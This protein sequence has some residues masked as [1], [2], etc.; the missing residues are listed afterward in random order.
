MATA[1]TVAEAVAA[2]ARE[3]V[4]GLDAAGQKS[5]EAQEKW[6]ANQLVRSR[7]EAWKNQE[8]LVGRRE[9]TFE[10]LEKARVDGRVLYFDA[11]S[12]PYTGL[13]RAVHPWEAMLMPP[14]KLKLYVFEPASESRAASER[15]LIQG[16]FPTLQSLIHS[17]AAADFKVVELGRKGAIH[18]EME[19]RR[20]GRQMLMKG[21]LQ[22]KTKAYGFSLEDDDRFFRAYD[23]EESMAADSRRWFYKTADLEWKINKERELVRLY[24]RSVNGRKKLKLDWSNPADITKADEKGFMPVVDAARSFWAK[25]D[26]KLEKNSTQHFQ[27]DGMYGFSVDGDGYLKEIYKDEPALNDGIARA[28]SR[29][30]FASDDLVL[31]LAPAQGDLDPLADAQGGFVGI[32]AAPAIGKSSKPLSIDFGSSDRAPVLVKGKVLAIEPE[33]GAGAGMTLKIYRSRRKVNKA[34]SASWAVQD[35]NQEML[36]KGEEKLNV[37]IWRWV[38][39]KNQAP[40]LLHRDYLE[41]RINRAESG[42]RSASRW[43]YMPYNWHN[44]ASEVP[45][46]VFKN[47]VQIFTGRDLNNDGFHGQVRARQQEGGLVR[48]GLFRKGLRA[49]DILE[50]IPDQARVLMDPTEFPSIVEIKGNLAPGEDVYGKMKGRQKGGKLILGKKFFNRMERYGRENEKVDLTMPEIFFN[51]GAREIFV[52]KVVGRATTLSPGDPTRLE[53]TYEDS[54]VSARSGR[55]AVA[56]AADLVGPLNPADP[57]FAVSRGMEAKAETRPKRAGLESITARVRVWLGYEGNREQSSRYHDLQTEREKE[58]EYHLSQ[59]EKLEKEAQAARAELAK[60]ERN[61]A[62]EKSSLNGLSRQT[63]RLGEQVLS[64]QALKDRRQRLRGYLDQL[65]RDMAQE[66]GRLRKLRSQTQ[67][68]AGRPKPDGGPSFKLGWNLLKKAAW[69]A[70]WPGAGFQW[71]AE[72]LPEKSS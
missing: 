23:D 38:N 40:I 34:S 53:G 1:K 42:A 3:I 24:G 46:G 32:Y 54:E 47:F 21:F 13:N 6:L 36:V 68:R 48:D 26:A 43:G 35:V 60:M 17:E 18:L 58:W 52:S 12:D 41:E 7:F 61:R 20:Q 66:R 2:G 33:S 14:Q 27:L 9:M 67:R 15:S 31:K 64:R 29:R 8:V 57:E 22:L 25:S 19:A 37:R 71:A 11:E 59:K 16:K 44:L 55:E 72:Q 69:A 5:K 62:V 56:A 4:G 10:D 39:K 70:I 45:R 49:I 51:Q 65:E 50:L 30:F 63:R 28:K